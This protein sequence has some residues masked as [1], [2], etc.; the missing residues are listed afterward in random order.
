MQVSPDDA[1]GQELRV[2]VVVITYNRREELLGNLGR[3]VALP[4]VTEVVV[5]DNAS[6]DGTADAVAAAYPT[7]RLIRLDQNLGAGGRTVG[8]QATSAEVVAFADDDSWWDPGALSLARGLFADCP[9]LG[10]VSGAI[11]VEPGG[12]LDEACQKMAVAP[13]DPSLPGPSIIG[14]LGCGAIVRRSAYL[15]VGGY[16]AIL[17][18]GGEERLLSLDLAAA[19]WAQCY[20]EALVARH[21][22]SPIRDEWPVRWARYRRN[23][24]LTAWLRLPLP[25]AFRET[26]TL[27]RAMVRDPVA[28]TELLPF[29]RLLPTAIRRR[30]LVP[31]S[32]LELLVASIAV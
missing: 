1:P 8:V 6:V 18:F 31:E 10:L 15:G 25:W 3:V 32:V 11:R 4:E 27:L 23:D 30:R 28:R 20:V 17:G 24:T 13:L 9:G 14:H 5:V 2:A 7:V 29:L 12:N 22:P 26:G 16:S 19:G 21:Q